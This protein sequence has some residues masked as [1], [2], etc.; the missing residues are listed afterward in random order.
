MYVSIDNLKINF[1]IFGKGEPILLLH[2]WGGSLESL[3]TLAKQL[4]TR[5]LQLILLDLPGFGKTLSPREDFSLDDYADLVEKFLKLQKI[6]DLY[7]FGHSFGGAIAI[8]LAVRKTI[9]IRKLILCNSSG[10]RQSDSG[11][12]LAISGAVKKLFSLPLLRSIY[13][14]IRKFFYYYIL[15]NRD[16]IDHQEIAGTFQRVVGE[17]ITSILKEVQVPTLLLWGELDMD[18]PLSHGKIMH[19]KIQNSR[20]QVIKG[21]SHGLPKIEPEIVQKEMMKFINQAII[22]A[23]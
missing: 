21:A 1:E 9:K 4:S 18:T 8:K 6:D 14:S 5:S 17:D 22:P 16:Y 19:S 20:L 10:I 2:G 23:V 3:K 11:K 12:Q 7:V 15:R 13:P